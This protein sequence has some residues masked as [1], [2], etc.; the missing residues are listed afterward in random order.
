[1]AGILQE[2]F[3]VDLPP[4]APEEHTWRSDGSARTKKGVS[5][6]DS[7]VLPPGQNIDRQRLPPKDNLPLVMGGET[8]VSRDFNPEACRNGYKRLQARPTDDEYTRAHQDAFYDEITVD[9]ETGFAE[10]NNVLD[11]L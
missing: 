4:A 8:D 7:V 10:R 1:M 9:G 2:K 3:Q 6:Q 5:G 11:R